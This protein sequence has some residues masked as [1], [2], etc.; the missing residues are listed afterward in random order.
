LTC[1]RNV[2]SVDAQAERR[3]DGSHFR[4]ARPADVIKGAVPRAIDDRVAREKL[5]AMGVQPEEL[6]GVQLACMGSW[7]TGT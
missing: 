7:E 6:T 2:A 3:C 1:Y 4:H 5:R